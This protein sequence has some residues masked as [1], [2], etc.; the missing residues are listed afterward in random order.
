MFKQSLWERRYLWK[1]WWFLQLYMRCWLWRKRLSRWYASSGIHFTLKLN[2]L[3]HVCIFSQSWNCILQMRLALGGL[4]MCKQE[5]CCIAMQLLC[6]WKVKTR[7]SYMANISRFPMR[8]LNSQK[9]NH[10]VYYEPIKCL[11]LHLKAVL[12][13]TWLIRLKVDGWIAKRLNPDLERL[14]WSYTVCTCLSVLIL[15]YVFY[16]YACI[17]VYFFNGKIKVYL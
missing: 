8:N 13:T 15:Q 6:K 9:N 5:I 17:C 14:I 12:F 7:C 3:S 1:Y 2:V 10:R 11:S 4:S 16:I